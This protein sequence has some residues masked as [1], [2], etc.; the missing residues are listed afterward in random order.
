MF[1]TH[2]WLRCTHW[3]MRGCLALLNISCLLL[4]SLLLSKVCMRTNTHTAHLRAE[5]QTMLAPCLHSSCTCKRSTC[6]FRI[7]QL[8][9]RLNSCRL[10]CPP[11]AMQAINA[12]CTRPYFN[13]G[14]FTGDLDGLQRLSL[15]TRLTLDCQNHPSSPVQFLG[16]NQ[17]QLGQLT[18][19]KHLQLAGIGPSFMSEYTQALQ[20]PNL[21]TLAV[22]AGLLCWQ[23]H[24]QPAWHGALPDVH[25]LMSSL[26]QLR[27]LQKILFI[28]QEGQPVCPEPSHLA[29][30]GAGGVSMLSRSLDYFKAA[31]AAGTAFGGPQ[32]QVDLVQLTAAECESCPWVGRGGQGRQQ[33]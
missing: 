16:P 25:S 26:R 14:P 32:L 5:L 10:H 31:L 8:S 2:C 9:M 20:L 24:I 1:C 29:N 30:N 22:P 3:N 18:Q 27:S 19:L 28:A 33:Q 23:C 13:P 4:V 15:L 21:E 6:K 17:P 11:C 7:H 12:V